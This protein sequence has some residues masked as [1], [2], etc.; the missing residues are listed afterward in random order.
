MYVIYL[1]EKD[2]GNVAKPATNNLDDLF[3]YIQRSFI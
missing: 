3:D 1:S 2:K